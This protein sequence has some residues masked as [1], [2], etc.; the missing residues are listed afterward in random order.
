MGLNGKALIR[1][2]KSFTKFL[3]ILIPFITYK[4]YTMEVNWISIV[5]SA[6]TPMVVGFIWYHQKVMGTAW[7][8]AVGMTEEKAKEANMGL[9]FGIS[10]VMSVLLTFFLLGFNN[11][12]GQEEAFDTFGHGAF[13]GAIVALFVA[14]PLFVTNGL[15]EQHSWKLMF[16]H[17]GYWVITLTIMGG[18]VDVMNHWPNVVPA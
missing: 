16:I 10:F 17:V 5:L 13:H 2:K 11:G 1:M 7:M 14:M 4:I 18:I 8:H 12:P 3:I 9:V 15:F 6:I